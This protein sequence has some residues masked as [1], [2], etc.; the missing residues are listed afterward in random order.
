[1]SDRWDQFFLKMALNASEMSKDP[2]SQV[3]AVIVG[4]DREIRSVGFNGFPRGVL[5]DDR[6]GDRDK[7][8]KLIVHAEMNAICNAARFGVPLKG[9]TMYLAATTKTGEIW[10]GPPCVRCMVEII[11][12]GI[13]KVVSYVPNVV[14]ERWSSD[15]AL[16]CELM[17]EAGIAYQ[18]VAVP[19]KDRTHEQHVTSYLKEASIPNDAAKDDLER[20]IAA[21]RKASGDANY[22]RRLADRWT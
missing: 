16:S 17:T 11:Q 13:T 1:M 5:D 12:L 9:C 14:S 18:E 4:P 8:L 3:G 2:R 10:A 19:V 7:K 15:M 6:L 22:Y 21:H 20:L